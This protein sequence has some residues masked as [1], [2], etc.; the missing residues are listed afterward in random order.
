MDITGISVAAGLLAAAVGASYAYVDLMLNRMGASGTAI[1]LNAAMPA[2]GWLLATPLMPWVLRR[3]NPGLV[4]AGLLMTAAVT[5]PGFELLH[6]ERAWM[7]FRFLF[8]GSCGLVFRLVEYWI[9]AVSPDDRRSRYIGIYSACFCGGAA[10]G[11]GA[12]PL[13]GFQGWPPVLLVLAFVAGSAAAFGRLRHGPPAVGDSPESPL[14]SLSGIASVGVVGALLFGMFEP[15][16]YALMPVYVVRQGIGEE[17]AA[18]AA[19]AFLAGQ[20][21]FSVPL[22]V[23]AD[24]LGKI[25]LLAFSAMVALGMTLVIPKTVFA[26]P[27]LLAAMF[28]WGG[29]AGALYT[30]SLALLTDV[31]EGSDL[32]AANAVFGTL[33]AVGSLTGGPLHGAAMDWRDPQGLMISAAALFAVFLTVLFWRTQRAEKP[34]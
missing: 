23:F 9:S 25:P 14:W 31:F 1:G 3:F 20:V 11:A 34:A 17:W 21:V 32:A 29:F 2:L 6:D 30:I 5:F 4:M 28:V 27:A 10:V 24:R 22:G 12:V 19:S 18:W 26:L 16:P 33:Y 7:L 13:V 8:G 15:V